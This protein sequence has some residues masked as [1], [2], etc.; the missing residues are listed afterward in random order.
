LHGKLGV[1]LEANLES[2]SIMRAD[3]SIWEVH[4]PG[5]HYAYTT[6]AAARGLCDLGALAHKSSHAD[7]ATHY[8]MVA[9]KMKAA[10]V[11]AFVDPQMALGGSI[12]GL[13]QQ[14]YYDGSLAEAFTWSLLPDLKGSVAT[15]TLDLFNHLRV[16]SGGF[17][18]NNDG[19]SSYDSNEWILVDLRISDALRRAGKPQPADQY[20]GQ[21]VQKA[22]ANFYLLPELYNDTPA[23]GQIGKYF[24]SIPMVGYGA[25]A[26]LM[27]VLDRGGGWEPNDCG[28]GNSM[29]GAAFSCDG[30]TPVGGGGANGGGG[31][32]GG[33]GAGGSS[34]PNGGTGSGI[35]APY[36]A[37]CLC[38]VGGAAPMGGTLLL[39][40]LPW[41]FIA[42]RLRARRRRS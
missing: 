5:K 6:M 13:Q 33:G 8:A 4:Q 3:S 15:A 35:D 2:S 22:A 12:E 14:K 1:P 39:V 16:D 27:T 25:G 30:V 10:F 23:D 20:L 32:T 37:A 40:A 24:G 31:S 29:S 17:K 19:L 9:A 7:D 26:Y 41:I 38:G 34:G 42:A 11:G 18:R 36:R 21:I 28:D